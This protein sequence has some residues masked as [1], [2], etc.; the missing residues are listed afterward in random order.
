MRGG[1]GDDAT[2]F[3]NDAEVIGLNLSRNY[4]ANTCMLEIHIKQPTLLSE[5]C[6][7]AN[8][9]VRD[10][11]YNSVLRALFS[12]LGTVT[13]RNDSENKKT[14]SEVI[15]GLADMKRQRA[16]KDK[17]LKYLN[18]I[19]TIHNNDK[20]KLT[21][22][23]EKLPKSENKFVI[24]IRVTFSQFNSNELQFKVV[25]YPRID[26]I[27]NIDHE[28]DFPGLFYDAKPEPDKGYDTITY[29]DGDG[30]DGGKKEFKSPNVPNV[31]FD[32]PLANF[33]ALKAKVTQLNKK[34]IRYTQDGNTCKAV[35][36]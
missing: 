21:Q 28:I 34:Q 5:A 27:E 31:I 11:G 32:I 9:D 17:Y 2:L 3:L 16:V 35:I 30:D 7:G 22:W 23:V 8:N 12:N 14:N 29:Y 19:Q 36:E 20:Q 15:F 13:Y 10:N 6:G 24:K 33:D 25:E 26:A 18:S 4:L 1:G